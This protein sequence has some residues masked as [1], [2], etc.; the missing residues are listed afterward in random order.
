MWIGVLVWKYG[1]R[2]Y[3]IVTVDSEL[4]NESLVQRSAA[5][6]RCSAFIEWTGWTL[7]IAVPWWQLHKRYKSY[8]YYLRRRLASAEGIVTFAVTL[9][10]CPL[11]R[12]Y[13]VSTARRI[14]L[15][16]EGNALY[17]VVSGYYYY[18]HYYYFKDSYITEQALTK[19]RTVQQ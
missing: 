6:W 10:V 9:C 19:T 5:T 4:D 8:Y 2:I 11:S 3:C 12:L 1:N 15:G 14:S 16:G 18:R 7:A 13:H 17:P